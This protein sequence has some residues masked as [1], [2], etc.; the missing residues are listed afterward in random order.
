[1][2]IADILTIYKD[3]VPENGIMLRE[4]IG[5]N[6]YSATLTAV[7]HILGGSMAEKHVTSIF[8]S[9]A[10]SERAHIIGVDA[11]NGSEYFSV[12]ECLTITQNIEPDDMI[13]FIDEDAEEVLYA[14]AYDIWND[15]MEMLNYEVTE[16]W[17]G[18]EAHVIY[19]QTRS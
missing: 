5:Q 15:N 9:T 8:L 18:S 14:R 17:L 7:A 6:A 19:I 16:V 2:K 12:G 4:E 10:P 11:I 3:I 1:M 13:A